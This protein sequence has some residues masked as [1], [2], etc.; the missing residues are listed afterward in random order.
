MAEHAF[1]VS[2][3]HVWLIMASQ[4]HNQDTV[5]SVVFDRA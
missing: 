3:D 4:N 5:V 2:L 1:S